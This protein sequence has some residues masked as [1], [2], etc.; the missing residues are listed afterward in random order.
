MVRTFYKLEM[1]VAVEVE[2]KDGGTSRGLDCGGGGSGGRGGGCSHAIVRQS[3][4]S[5]QGCFDTGEMDTQRMKHV[6]QKHHLERNVM[7]FSSQNAP[8]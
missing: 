7:I 5:T 3:R 8:I 1:E 4:F 2:M 6:S